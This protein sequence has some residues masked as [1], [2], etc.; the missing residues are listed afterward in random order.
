MSAL[1]VHFGP[2]GGFADAD[3]NGLADDLEADRDADGVADAVEVDSD[4]DGVP[5]ILEVDANRDRVPDVFQVDENKDGVPDAFQVDQNQDGTPDVF[6]VDTNHD[7]VP[8]IMQVDNNED[9][10]PDAYQKPAPATARDATVLAMLRNV[11]GARAVSPARVTS[12]PIFRASPK[13]APKLAS[14]TTSVRGASPPRFVRA[15]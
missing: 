14:P 2:H 9:G 11:N 5:D 8:D 4:F 6:Q 12:A 1:E 7:G 13:P 3:H 15:S 10:V